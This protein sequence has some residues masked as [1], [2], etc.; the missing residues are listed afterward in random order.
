MSRRKT[1]PLKVCSSDDISKQEQSTFDLD[2]NDSAS[3]ASSKGNQY[4]RNVSSPPISSHFI[5][6]ST[7]DHSNG[8]MVGNVNN[9]LKETATSSRVFQGC[10]DGHDTGEASDRESHDRIE[11]DEED[12]S[13]TNRSVWMREDK[14]DLARAEE[15]IMKNVIGTINS[16]ATVEEKH[17]RLNEIIFELEWIK[18]DLLKKDPINAPQVALRSFH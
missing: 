15:K 2:T 14:C 16:A 6:D 17:N 13:P 4:F 12:D 8:D 10:F 5:K 3:E 9:S 11:T 18:E 1:L 7:D